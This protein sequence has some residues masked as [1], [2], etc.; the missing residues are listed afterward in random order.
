MD[1]TDGGIGSRAEKKGTGE[2]KKR[3]QEINSRDRRFT[4]LLSR[5]FSTNQTLDVYIETYFRGAVNL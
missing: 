2:G 1:I 4:V 5:L 3:Y